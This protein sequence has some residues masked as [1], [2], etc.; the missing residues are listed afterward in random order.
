MFLHIKIKYWVRRQNVKT[1]IYRWHILPPY[2]NYIQC[3]KLLKC[4]ENDYKMA[5]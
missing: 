3:T 4:L 5:K 1:T 2:N